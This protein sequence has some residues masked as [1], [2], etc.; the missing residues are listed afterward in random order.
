[1][2]HSGK[3]QEAFQTTLTEEGQEKLRQRAKNEVEDMVPGV[4]Y[5]IK[6]AGCPWGSWLPHPDN[7]FT[8]KYRHTWVCVRCKRPRD[9]SFVRCPMP[10]RG[11]DEVD[12]NASLVMTYF[13]PFTLNPD[14]SAELVPFLGR[15][16]PA[17]KT[18]NDSFRFWLNGR[19][20]TSESNKYIHNFIVVTHVR[21]GD[22]E[23]EARSDEQVRDEELE[24]NKFSFAEVIKTR[25]GGAVAGEN[26]EEA[27]DDSK[28]GARQ[29]FAKA[30]KM[31]EIPPQSTPLRHTEP[32]PRTREAAPA[33]RSR[34][35]VAEAGAHRS[36]KRVVAQRSFLLGRVQVH[37]ARHLAVVAEEK[38]DTTKDESFD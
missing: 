23:E 3:N 19:I 8:Q 5:M 17:D 6:D 18:W 27:G 10:R 26:D 32:R 15:L 28:D 7:G 1:L 37:G 11:S 36:K 22:T 38:K 25:I 35:R 12:R 31:W 29:A 21:P 24:V 33:V 13:H 30:H 4:D 34:G 9:P 16:C 14:M 20:L 2:N